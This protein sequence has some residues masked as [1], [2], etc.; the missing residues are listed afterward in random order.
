MGLDEIEKKHSLRLCFFLAN[1]KS[2]DGGSESALK[3]DV[4]FTILGRGTK[5]YLPHKKSPYVRKR[6]GALQ[7]N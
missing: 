6:I 7:L 2:H 4:K 5:H 1:K 3:N